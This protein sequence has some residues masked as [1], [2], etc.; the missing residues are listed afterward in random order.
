LKEESSNEK[1]INL[2]K[3]KPKNEKSKKK[4]KMKKKPKKKLKMGEKPY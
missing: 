3:W 4:N 1:E 2:K